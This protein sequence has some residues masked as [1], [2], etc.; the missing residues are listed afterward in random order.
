M[1]DALET[2]SEGKNSWQHYLTTWNQNYFVPALSKAKSVFINTS[3]TAKSNSLSE[4]K[5]ETSKTRCPD[6]KNFLAK[7]SS[8]KVKKKYFLKCVIGCE[9]IVLFRSDFNKIWEAP[10]TKTSPDENAPKP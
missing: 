4:R 6:C 5:Y 10:K 3:S 2:I 9:N 1:E 8:S 7:I